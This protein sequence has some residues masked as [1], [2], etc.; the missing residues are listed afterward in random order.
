MMESVEGEF[1]PALISKDLGTDFIGQNILCYPTLPSTMDVAE[2]VAKEGAVEG[3]IVVAQEQTGGRGRLGRKW[4]SPPGSLSLSIILRPTPIYLPRLIMVASLAA[5]HSIETVTG[6]KTQIKWPNDI[7]IRGKK[8][9]GILVRSELRGRGVD[10]AVMGIGMNVNLHPSA[11]PEISLI[12][13]SLSKERGEEISLL[14]TVQCLLREV[15]R[16]YLAAKAEEPLNEEWRQRLETLGKMIR[17][18]W[19][20]R[21]LCRVCGPGW[22]PPPASLRWQPG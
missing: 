16:F 6:L 3:T 10:F 15:E 5:S 1:T 19:S 8:V 7:L 2:Q 4:I 9:C 13:T 14:M 12:A 22:Q 21:G 11:F 20:E 18:K 17:A